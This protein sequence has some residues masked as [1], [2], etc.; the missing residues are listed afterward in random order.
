M[1]PK[2]F[3][4]CSGYGVSDTILN[5]FD[6]ALQECGIGDYNHITVSSVLPPMCIQRECVNLPRGSLLYS[7]YSKITSNVVGTTL[8]AAIAIGIPTDIN[9]IGVIMEFSGLV[10]KEDAECSVRKM[11]LLAMQNRM[12]EVKQIIVKAMSLCV[13][14]EKHHTAI[15]FVSMW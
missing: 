7:A 6:N 15:A 9:E 2:N 13:K 12:I 4:I 8:S 10:S 11:T 3:Y 14:N 1:R 5:S